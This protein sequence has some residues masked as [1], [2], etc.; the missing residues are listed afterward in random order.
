ML[1][2]HRQPSPARAMRFGAL[3]CAL[4]LA[5]LLAPLSR[6][7]D[8]KAKPAELE[9]PKAFTKAAP[10]SV[11]DLKAIQEHVA[12]VV[13]KAMPAVV[14]VRVGPAQG[15]GVIISEDGYVLTAG[16]V[17]G[18]PGQDVTLN[19]P[20]GTKFK[21]KTLGR[22]GGI[23]SGLIKIT[24][25]GKFP[26]V[27]MGKSGEVKAG[28]WCMAI[29][30]PGGMQ[31]GRSPPVR[32][33]RVLRS[34]PTLI[35]SDCTLVGGDSGGPLFDMRGRV[36]GIHSRISQGIDINIHVPVDTYRETWDRLVAGESW[37][38]GFGGGFAQGGPWL[39]VNRDD[40]ARVCRIAS[41]APKSPAEKAGLRDGDV[42]V[43]FN[44]QKIG[45]F[46]DLADQVSRCKIGQPVAVEVQREDQM[47]TFKVEIGKRP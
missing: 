26:F 45:T 2:S 12:R 35:Q 1:T 29:G 4:G 36:I 28:E 24:E 18:R 23:D 21:G 30:H 25:K 3:A 5:A 42:I 10:E 31:P 8:T 37:G 40:N 11:E 46:D 39:G 9:P 14:N 34:G 16:H 38:S 27:E 17:S 15:S 6:A 43:V 47:M 33:G 32:L 7:G 41:V 13:K 20:D 19:L 44:G 22:N